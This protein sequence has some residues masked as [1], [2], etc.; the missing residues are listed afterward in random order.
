LISWYA[1]RTAPAAQRPHKLSAGQSIVEV[2]LTLGNFAHYMPVHDRVFIHRRTK[3][4]T[5]NRAPLLPGYIFVADVVEWLNL[6]DCVG[7]A[8]VLGIGG[9]PVAIPNH[10]IDNLRKVEQAVN[11]ESARRAERR[12][13]KRRIRRKWGHFKAQLTILTSANN[14]RRESPEGVLSGQDPAGPPR[15]R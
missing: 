14:V 4:M 9:T 15:N 3:K 13:M 2:A 7:V 5:S 6:C 8:G 1:V 12:L 11:D 10:Q